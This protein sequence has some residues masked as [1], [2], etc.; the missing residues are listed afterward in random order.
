[1]CSFKMPDKIQ[2]VYL[3]YIRC[4]LLLCTSFV[5]DNYSSGISERTVGVM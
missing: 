3:H 2:G 4:I 5:F 1:M